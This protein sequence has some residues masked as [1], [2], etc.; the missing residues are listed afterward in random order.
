MT[1]KYRAVHAKNTWRK[2]NSHRSLDSAIRG[3]DGARN[4]LL[5]RDVWAR[6]GTS[7]ARCA[8]SSRG[9]TAAVGAQPCA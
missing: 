3:N 9:K 6:N 7:T 1:I 5:R 4:L 2:V 8:A